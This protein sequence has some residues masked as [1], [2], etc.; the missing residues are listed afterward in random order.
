MGILNYKDLGIQEAQVILC[1]D[2]QAGSLPCLL[3]L[4]EY[5]NY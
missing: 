2:G 4:Y 3:V 1:F 5:P